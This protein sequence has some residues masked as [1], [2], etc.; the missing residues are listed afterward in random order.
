M[1]F[2][3]LSFKALSGWKQICAAA[4]F[5]A[6]AWIASPAQTLTSLASF[7]GT[8]GSQPVASLTQGFDGNF[9][10]TTSAGGASA[11]AYCSFTGCGTVFEM[12]PG[13]TLSTLYNFCT[14]NAECT[15]GMFSYTRLVQAADGNFYGTTDSGGTDLGG[16][17]FKMTPGG[18]L[19]TLHSFD[20]SEGADPGSLVQFLGSFY[21]VTKFGA[22][23]YGTAF[24]MT[25][26]GAVTTLHNFDN[27]DGSHPIALV[28]G[29]DGNLYGLTSQGG[30]LA[31]TYLELPGCGTVFKMTPEGALTTLYS[32]CSQANCT[33][34]AGP[35]TLIQGTDGSLYGTTYAGGNPTCTDLEGVIGCGTVFKITP[36]G[37]FTTLFTFCHQTNCTTEGSFDGSQPRAL[38]Q[39]TDGNLYGVAGG[40]GD[41]RCNNGYG[42]GTI[43]KLTV[44]D[45]L[46]TLYSFQGAD[47]LQPTSLMQATNG[48]FYGATVNGGAAGDGT[49][50]SL[51]VGL[52]PFVAFTLD[53]GKAGQSGPILGQGLT[54][55]TGVSVNGMPASFTIVSDTYIQATVPAGATSGYVTVT[56]PS[57]TL[58]SNVPFHV[59]P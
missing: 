41:R 10:G 36:A 1:N 11:T 16:T 2:R 20:M 58:T 40:G 25:R 49:V 13:G 15:D 4:L 54:G 50:F 5:C 12:T 7:D 26:A 19:A 6:T 14:A 39:A 24:K 34:G 53:A 17:A 18:T 44:A 3:N 55:T 31:C 28:Q 57:G 59:I 45:A 23:G 32:F 9:Y 46:T 21:G 43:F 27:T 52:G 48:T 51:S 33:D 38:L 47:G 35:T 56:T 42:C 8:D 37:V 30:N 29:T 22:N